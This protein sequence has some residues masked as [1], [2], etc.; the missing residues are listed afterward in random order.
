MKQ[1]LRTE[2]WEIP[3]EVL[4]KGGETQR[5]DL[6]RV[7]KTYVDR[8]MLN[9]QDKKIRNTMKDAYKIL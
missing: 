8:R 4:D 9:T 6:E 3:T 1:G 7:S 2:P 5:R